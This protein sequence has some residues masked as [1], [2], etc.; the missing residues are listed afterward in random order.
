M[1]KDLAATAT[2]T[3]DAPASDVWD[4]LVNPEKIKQYMFGT[5]VVS[6]FKEGSP[7]TWK[8]EWKGKPYEDKGVIK[9]AAPG[10]VLEY[11]HN[12]HRVIVE[13]SGSDGTTNVRLRQDTPERVLEFTHASGQ[14]PAEVHTVTIE[15]SGSDGTTNVRLSQDNN[16]NQKA[17]Q[18][19]EKNWSMMLDSMKKL[20]EQ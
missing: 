20:L 8:G 3:I 16:A 11:T 9:R 5:N 2:T 6:D 12:E 15:L 14:N 1:E 19:S 13:L 7:I 10:R 4:A 17:K 18:E